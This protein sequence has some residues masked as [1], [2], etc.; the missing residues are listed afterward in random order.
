MDTVNRPCSHL[1][2]GRPGADWQPASDSEP[3]NSEVWNDS[4]KARRQI[5]NLNLNPSQARQNSPR[6]KL[7]CHVG[8]RFA[9]AL[10]PGLFGKN[11]R[12]RNAY[13]SLQ[14]GRA[15]RKAHYGAST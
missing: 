15:G 9:A 5:S 3:Q 6:G 11:P 2:P 8:R 1:E 14:S 12:S 4:F 13:V 10:L 7:H